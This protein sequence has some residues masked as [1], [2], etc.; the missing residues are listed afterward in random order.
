MTATEQA[1]EAIE[2]WL[3]EARTKSSDSQSKTID[4]LVVPTE[5]VHRQMM[6][7][8]VKSHS[9]TDALY[10]LDRALHKKTVDVP[11]H[12]KQVRRL[13]KQQFLAKAHLAKIQESLGAE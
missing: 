12:L 11:T 13:A 3:K 8:A 9:I 6:E 7:L 2:E 1:K 10:F 5:P 4:E